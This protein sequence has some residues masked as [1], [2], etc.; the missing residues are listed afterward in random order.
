MSDFDK[1]KPFYFWCQKVLPL[2]YDDSLSYYE[3]LCKLK[4]KVNELILV[5][6]NLGKYIDQKLGELI[7]EYI[8]S[9]ALDDMLQNL[10]DEYKEDITLTCVEN[11]D[12]VGANAILNV[13]GKVYLFDTGYQTPSAITN[14]LVDNNLTDIRG[15]IISHVDIDHVGNFGN[16]I[17]D[18]RLDF[19]QCTVYLPHGNINWGSVEGYAVVNDELV[20][21]RQKLQN[22][23]NNIVTLATAKGLTMVSPDEGDEIIL[24]GN[25]KLSFHNLKT[26]YF[27]QYYT[28]YMSSAGAYGV[29]I[30]GEKYYNTQYNN[31][32]MISR[33][34]F[35]NHVINIS[36]DVQKLAEELNYQTWVDADIVLAPHHGINKIVS[37][38][39]LTALNPSVFVVQTGEYNYAPFWL[40]KRDVVKALYTGAAC[41]LTFQ[42]FN[43]T[44][45]VPA[46][47]PAYLTYPGIPF[48]QAQI[49]PSLDW[50]ELVAEV[51]DTGR[52]GKDINKMFYPG[53]WE[54]PNATIAQTCEH[55]PFT[56]CGFKLKVEFISEFRKI[57][58]TAIANTSSCTI[59]AYRRGTIANNY[60]IGQHP[61]TDGTDYV[62]WTSWEYIYASQYISRM[63]DSDD[64]VITT[65]NIDS[66]YSRIRSINNVF[67]INFRFT[68]GENVPAGGKIIDFVRDKKINAAYFTAWD[69]TAGASVPMSV[70]SDNDNDPESATYRHSSFY[71][72]GGLISGHVYEGTFTTILNP[73][74]QY[75]IED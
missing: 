49:I 10:L 60:T 67:T 46:T 72:T 40:T 31:F 2:V 35:W 65:T 34:K 9:G 3:V 73:Y 8:R 16:I 45:T 70:S 30:D 57:L 43:T 4:S 38:K 20:P 17:N 14:Y 26:E 51:G 63:L 22:Q 21:Y 59:I 50:G 74:E 68:A 29:T 58:Q 53:Q 54:I 18:Q 66:T 28:E 5:N 23:Y 47:S 37:E 41:A 44:I 33:I 13:H 55:T 12:P 42:S 48:D 52:V 61:E 24:S 27:N 32:S 39:Y 64:F 7:A 62:S 69:A 25:C 6:N 19:S 56:F 36:G 15:I 75:E 71:A 11:G 1:I